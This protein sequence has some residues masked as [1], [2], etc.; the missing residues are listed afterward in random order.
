MSTSVNLQDL[1]AAFEWIGAGEAA[2]V[3]CEAYVSRAT[4]AIHWS[5][6]GADEEL[7]E[8]IEDETKYVAVPGKSDLELGRSL[9]LRF[10]EER[11]PD[12]YELVHQY[13]RKK[14]AYSRFKAEL[15]RAG[16]LEAWY[17]YEQRAIEESLREWGEENGF[18]LERQPSSDYGA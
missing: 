2:G 16:Q 4:G 8:D 10:V 7:P 3:D 1:L 13:F 17:E 9:A 15:E 5:G 6:E 12:S 11:L 18:V 14:G